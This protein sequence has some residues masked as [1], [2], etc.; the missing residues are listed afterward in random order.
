MSD[1][2]LLQDIRESLNCGKYSEPISLQLPTM[3]RFYEDGVL[4]ES[5]KD[6][7][8][9]IEVGFLSIIDEHNYSDPIMLGTGKALKR[10]IKNVAP[11]VINPLK[12][13]Q[14]DIDAILIAT[15]MV[16]R[17]DVM[18][19]TQKCNHVHDDGEECGYEN[20]LSINLMDHISRYGS[21]G[22]SNQFMDESLFSLELPSI[23]QTVNLK[24]PEYGQTIDLMFKAIRSQ[25]LTKHYQEV[26]EDDDLMDQDSMVLEAYENYIHEVAD[27][28]ITSMQNFVSSVVTS[29][30]TEIS[31]PEV[32]HQWLAYLPN[33]TAKLLADSIN[34]ITSAVNDLSKIDYQCQECGMINSITL[35][36]D[37]E[38]LFLSGSEVEDM[39]PSS[40]KTENTKET[41]K[42]YSKASQKSRS[43]QKVR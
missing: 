37:Q 41:K 25:E 14:V 4:D 28:D 33:D 23:K 5:V 9:N 2:P 19:F 22:Q 43:A 38:R 17:G 36:L 8:W 29:K 21:F 11:E 12:L 40:K 1:N 39:T 3:G 42:N 30:G 7:D 31:D 24:L 18:K 35:N 10:I 26:A 20:N 27:N 32:I 13:N 15:R 6:D 34:E 16:S